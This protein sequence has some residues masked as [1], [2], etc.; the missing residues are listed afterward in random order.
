MRLFIFACLCLPIFVHAQTQ[1]PWMFG[2]GFGGGID[3]VHSTSD[4][5]Y[6]RVS[7]P[8]VQVGYHLSDAWTIL[9]YAPGGVDRISPENKAFE[10]LTFSARYAMSPRWSCQAGAGLGL[11][12]TPFYAVDYAD[13]PPPVYI[14]P[15]VVAELEYRLLT[16]GK[17]WSLCAGAR[18]LYANIQHTPAEQHMATDL[19][20]SIKWNNH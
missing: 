6:S 10:A 17:N 8:N 18:V 5:R 16:F 14:G 12:I 9:F 7:L 1:S 13:G 4:A 2:V 19:L 15:A 3:F 20:I 11:D